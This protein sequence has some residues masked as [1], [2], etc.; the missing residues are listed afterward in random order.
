MQTKKPLEDGFSLRKRGVG[1]GGS[2]VTPQISYK[3]YFGNIKDKL[4]LCMYL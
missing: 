3:K 1:V 2:I 4:F